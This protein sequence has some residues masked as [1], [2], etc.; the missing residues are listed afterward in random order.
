MK[1][2]KFAPLVYLS[3]AV[4]LLA[5]FTAIAVEVTQGRLGGLDRS[6]LLSFR[7]PGNSEAALG[8]PWLKIVA[9]DVT[10]LGSTAVITLLTVVALG[11]LALKRLWGDALL[12]LFAIGGGTAVNY[13]LKDLIQRGRPTIAPAE[14]AETYTYS[15]PSG[16]AFMSAATFLTFGLLLART[17]KRALI[18]A[19]VLGAAIGLTILIGLTRLY[20]GVHWPTD[21][22]A[23]WCAGA[24]WAILCWSVSAWLRSRPTP[25]H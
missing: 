16:H 5:V 22:F 24:A 18:R 7:E 19:Y 17:Q 14:V 11:F 20:L 13:A 9:D 3:V 15:F 6:L 1:P 4:A 12:V 25:T 2:K 23:G 8:P 21:V 10:D